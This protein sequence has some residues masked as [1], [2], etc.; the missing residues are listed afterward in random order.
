MLCY[1][2]TP[3]KSARETPVWSFKQKLDKRLYESVSSSREPAASTPSNPVTA[4]VPLGDGAFATAS[5]N[6][7]VRSVEEPSGDT[8]AN[9]VLTS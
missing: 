1:C 8:S 9:T 7:Q 2:T 5:L 3:H 6:G 4:V